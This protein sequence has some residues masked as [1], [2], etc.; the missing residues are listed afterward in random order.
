VIDVVA[1]GYNQSKHLSFL[2]QSAG[3]ELLE[4]FKNEYR[5]L[6]AAGRINPNYARR[7]RE[8]EL[9]YLRSW[10][11]LVGK[12]SKLKWVIT[13]V[14]KADLWRR[15]TEEVLDHYQGRGEYAAVIKQEFSEI[16]HDVCPLSCSVNGF[17]DLPPPASSTKF[18]AWRQEL[19]D[20]FVST[21][22]S[23]LS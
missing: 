8:L 14:N 15:H 10:A 2:A 5:P 7:E 11:S 20:A 3:P 17:Y 19:A 6:N 1:Y 13:V 4:E 16:T 23:R 21:L 12:Q 9:Y 22:H 18:A